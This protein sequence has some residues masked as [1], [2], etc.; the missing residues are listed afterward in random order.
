MAV[1]G[2]VKREGIPVD[3]G[4]IVFRSQ[5]ASGGVDVSAATSITKGEYRF[6]DEDGPPVGKYKVEIVMYPLRDPN[7]VGKKVD[8]PLLN[9]DRFKNKMPVNGWVKD[10][11]V[12]SEGEPVIDFNVE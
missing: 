6:T 7:F 3:E 4:N 8:A 12:P 11:D 1:S 10:A 9:D 2:T 5:A